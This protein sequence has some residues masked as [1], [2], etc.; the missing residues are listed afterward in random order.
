[1]LPNEQAVEIWRADRSEP[2][3]IEQVT[4]LDGSLLF[5]GL[6]ID[7]AEIWVV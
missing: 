2:E 4:Q 5:P 3:R 6:V 1:L 7:L